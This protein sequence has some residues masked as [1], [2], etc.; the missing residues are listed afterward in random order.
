[1]SFEALS[2]EDIEV[3]CNCLISIKTQK[4]LTYPDKIQRLYDLFYNEGKKR[5]LNGFS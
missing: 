4:N 2:N 3:L 1:V 5:G